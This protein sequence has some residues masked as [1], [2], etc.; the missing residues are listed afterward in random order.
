MDLELALFVALGL[1]IV[2]A[3][4][5]T[6][7]WW[8]TRSPQPAPA[9]RGMAASGG[10]RPRSPGPVVAQQGP[11]FVVREPLHNHR[12]QVIGYRLSL[13]ADGGEPGRLVELL[14]AAVENTGF[15]S[16]QRIPRLFVRLPLAALDSDRLSLL[17]RQNC[18]LMVVAALGPEKAELAQRFAELRAAGYTPG[19]EW[20]GETLPDESLLAEIRYL[21]V[22]LSAI[23]RGRVDDLCRRVRCGGRA[24]LVLTGIDDPATFDWAVGAYPSYLAGERF[25]AN[26]AVDP[27]DGC[28]NR[29]GYLEVIKSLRDEVDL[30]ELAEQIKRDPM[31]TYRLL[32][33]VNSPYFGLREPVES[34]KQALALLGQRE[35]TKWIHITHLTRNLDSDCVETVNLFRDAMYRARFMEVLAARLMGKGE[36]SKGFLT[37]L[38]SVLADMMGGSVRDLQKELLLPAEVFSALSGREGTLTDLLRLAEVP[39][40]RDF[41]L[42]EAMSEKYG[43]EPEALSEAVMEGLE[44]SSE[45][46]ETTEDT[47]PR[48]AADRPD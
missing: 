19:L 27:R 34:V 36:A 33:Y 9:S 6:A 16:L 1:L 23:P 21:G 24:R 2:A 41:A 7:L 28:F 14:A 17:P 47:T 40:T 31:L 39:R 8:R 13:L 4:V 25:A 12:S 42:V 20:D 15:S 11:E 48:L 10:S 43:F 38:F 46:F 22:D 5:G 32:R 30:D 26:E 29:S 37:G 35:I 45:L 44:W 3:G 18:V